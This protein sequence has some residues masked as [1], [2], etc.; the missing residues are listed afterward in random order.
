LSYEEAVIFHKVLTELNIGMLFLAAMAAVGVFFAAA[1]SRWTDFARA[2]DHTCFAAACAG[3]F[4]L[5]LS[6]LT[7]LSAWPWDRL[8]RTPL[9]YGKVSYVALALALWATLIYKRALHGPALWETKSL[10]VPSLI[11]C[12]LAFS[13]TA[14]AGSAGGHLGHG[15]SVLDFVL[16]DFDPYYPFVLPPWLSL[17]IIVSGMF[18]LLRRISPSKSR[19]KM[20][21]LDY[22]VA[23][24]FFLVTAMATRAFWPEARLIAAQPMQHEP[25]QN[26]QDK[27]A[28]KTPS[29]EMS[30]EM[31][32]DEMAPLKS[33][34]QTAEGASIKIL[35]PKKGEAFK[36]DQIPLQ[37]KL[38][39]GKRGEHVHAYVDGEM[40][41]M[42]KTEKGTLT[43]IKPGKHVLELRVATPN[44]QT[45]LNATDRVEF[46]VK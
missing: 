40:M 8:W 2:A 39:K 32:H 20:K 12:L 10:S 26:S 30:G 3:V 23:G 11:C 9:I 16:F 35:S 6:A 18:L 33:A 45:E 31:K 41:G 24:V 42:F 5:I 13:A 44:H 17:G 38:V 1:T 36:G 7:G 19:Q 29:H 43:G 14:L 15:V 4:F 21:A 27:P 37:F 46:V 28:H 34:L 22:M 25:V